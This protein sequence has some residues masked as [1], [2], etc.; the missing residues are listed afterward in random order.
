MQRFKVTLV[1]FKLLLTDG[2]GLLKTDGCL[3]NAFP[4]LNFVS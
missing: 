3:F 1:P 2:I 4:P